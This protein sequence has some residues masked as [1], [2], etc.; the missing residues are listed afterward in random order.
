MDKLYK[1][2][3][4]SI[5]AT[6][7]KTKKAIIALGCSF[8]EGQGAISEE[9]Y[10]KYSW[11]GQ[12]HGYPAVS[13]SLSKS[14]QDELSKEFP[15]ITISNEGQPQFFLHEYK[16]SFVSV[17]ANKYLNGEY[18]AINLGTAGCGNRATIKELYFHPDILWNELEEIIVIYCP[19]GAERF[20]FADDANF[21]LNTHRNWVAMWPN[22]NDFRGPRRNLWQGYKEALYSDKSEILEQIANVQELILWCKSKNARLI[23]TPAFQDVYNK[24][25]FKSVLSKEI[26]R[27]QERRL[28]SEQPDKLDVT[29]LMDLW[30]WDRMFAPNGCPTFVDLVMQQEF[31]E[32]KM[33]PHFYSFI[34]TG[35]ANKWLTPCAHPS[36]KGHDLFA[37]CLYEHIKGIV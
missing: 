13:W 19:S 7:R 23:I 34:G 15:E 26:I 2:V 24:E 36:P 18:A 9:V 5:N 37:K 1:E 35:T 25:H 32:N 10:N 21:E 20:D 22:I 11:N 30:P 17:L 3:I 8:V 4:P 14:Q 16:N 12:Q 29:A 33:H 27:D 31:P 6:I 28:K